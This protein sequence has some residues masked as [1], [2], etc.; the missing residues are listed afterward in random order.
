MYDDN[1]SQDDFDNLDF[2]IDLDSQGLQAWLDASDNDDL[3]YA[4][5]ILRPL[6]TNLTLK[7]LAIMDLVTNTD[8]ADGV[9]DR[10]RKLG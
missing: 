7:E 1:L 5:E 9:L 6:I 3:V 10:I 8:L 4:L 2:L